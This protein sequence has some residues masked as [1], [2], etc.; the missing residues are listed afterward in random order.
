MAKIVRIKNRRG[1]IEFNMEYNWKARIKKWERGIDPTSS[2][3]EDLKEY[4]ET[5]LFWYALDHLYGDDLWEFLEYDFEDFTTKDFNRLGRPYLKKL[6]RYLLCNGVPIAQNHKHL[7]MAQTLVDCIIGGVEHPSTNEDIEFERFMA[8]FEALP[9]DT[10]LTNDV[11]STVDALEALPIE[12]LPVDTNES[13]LPV[14]TYELDTNELAI[15]LETHEPVD[16]DERN[17]LAIPSANAT[18]PSISTLETDEPVET[19]EPAIPFA[20][21]IEPSVEDALT[22]NTLASPRSPLRSIPATGFGQLHTLQRTNGSAIPTYTSA[23]PTFTEFGR[24]QA[25]QRTG[26]G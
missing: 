8:I 1:G 14:D 19:D 20:N 23:T 16:I 11:E 13:A 24:F 12:A 18:K 21:T 26:V 6:R 3:D 7:S 15:P 9:R 4:A 10:E 2:S 25:L 22:F 5:M 17:Q